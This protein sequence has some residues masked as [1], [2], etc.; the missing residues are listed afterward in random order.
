MDFER[1][2]IDKRDKTR[3]EAKR[4]TSP[5]RDASTLAASAADRVRLDLSA[6]QTTAKARTA[7][8]D[9]YQKLV[10]SP[11]SHATFLRNTNR[12]IAQDFKGGDSL[13][14]FMTNTL[15]VGGEKFSQVKHLTAL[16]RESDRWDFDKVAIATKVEIAALSAKFKS[17][18]PGYDLAHFTFG[19]EAMIRDMK[20]RGIE[21][22]TDLKLPSTANA[23]GKTPANVALMMEMGSKADR[24]SSYAKAL[25][26]AR[27][28][29]VHTYAK[30]ETVLRLN[31]H[32]K[33]AYPSIA[34][35]TVTRVDEKSFQVTTKHHEVKTISNDTVDRIPKVND[36]IMVKHD[37][38]GKGV[39]RDMPKERG[40]SHEHTVGR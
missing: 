35:G 6:L 16:E 37:A 23:D 40:H 12:L 19:H 31:D 3:E 27:P 28:D 18:D 22:N 5:E 4:T 21:V 25:Y 14:A 24:D 17:L 2:L 8:Y 26:E 34:F 30:E 13:Y 33:A 36:T 39:V 15:T 29:I 10:E 7:A 9:N 32:A 38:Q 11:E 20:E 1:T